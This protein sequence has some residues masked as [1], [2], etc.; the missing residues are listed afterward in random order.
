MTTISGDICGPC[1]LPD[2]FSCS[3]FCSTENGH[4]YCTILP[5][6][7]DCESIN[8]IYGDD[9]RDVPGVCCCL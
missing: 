9:C 7:S 8:A 4:G 5:P 1:T 2:G 6:G 3:A